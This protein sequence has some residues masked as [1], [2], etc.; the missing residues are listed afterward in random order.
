MNFFNLL[1]L[2]NC[3]FS[4][5][6]VFAQS[7][8]RL[9]ETAPILLYADQMSY[10]QELGILKAT[11]HVEI[12]QEGNLLEADTVTYNENTDEVTASGHVRLRDSEGT[13]AFVEYMVLKG[14]LKEGFAK[15]ARVLMRDQSRIAAV[16]MRRLNAGKQTEF[17][18]ASYTPCARCQEKPKEPPLWQV[19]ARQI[20]RDTEGGETTYLDSQLNISDIPVLYIPYL[21]APLKR[22]SGFLLP[23][24]GSSKQLGVHVGLPY[25]W[26]ID[27]QDGSQDLTITPRITTKQG[28]ILSGIYRKQMLTGKFKIDGSLNATGQSSPNGLSNEQGGSLRG[29]IFADGNFDLNDRWRWGFQ[30]SQVSDKSYLKTRPF[31]NTPDIALYTSDPVLES[32]LF[33]EGFSPRNYLSLEGFHYIGLRDRERFRNTPVVLPVFDYYYTSAPGL[34][35]SFLTLNTNLMSLYRTDGNNTRRIVVDGKGFLP[36]T[37]ALGQTHT[38]FGRLRGDLYDTKVIAKNQEIFHGITPRF[39][40]Q[41]GL[42]SRWPFMHSSQGIIL[43]PILQIIG[44]PQGNPTYKIPDEDSQGFEFNEENL[45]IPDRFPGLDRLDYGSRTNYGFQLL[46]TNNALANSLLFLGQSYSFTPPSRGLKGTGI[47]TRLSDIVGR[48]NM[49]PSWGWFSFNYRFRLNKNNLRARYNET[50]ATL[51]PKILNLSAT[52]ILTSPEETTLSS[53]KFQQIGW[54]LNSQWTQFWSAQFTMTRNLETQANRWKTLSQGVGLNYHDECLTA[55]IWFY[56]NYYSSIGVRPGNAFLFSIVFK[57]LG[58]VT[59]KRQDDNKT[60]SDPTNPFQT[61]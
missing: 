26:V 31:F 20:I 15:E 37:N 44:G 4:T 17:D 2:L 55:G 25:Y 40:P 8:Q 43:E 47:G 52:Y 18:L 5:F 16:S 34:W 10:A 27:P 53:Q 42:D 54:A 21:N 11:G 58:G 7:P 24:I 1:L 6:Y 60:T 57:N 14:D 48:F 23:S 36:Y 3:F 45:L 33:A 61:Y 28:I 12:E 32:R 50:E 38:L 9:S 59:F 39:F 49:T 30:E 51:G 22:R 13:V 29:H 19:Q 46:T 56:K 41:I 35:G